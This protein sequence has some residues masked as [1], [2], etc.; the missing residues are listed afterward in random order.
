MKE[1]TDHC[2][3]VKVSGKVAPVEVRPITEDE[4]VRWDRLMADRHYLGSRLVGESVRYVALWEGRWAALLGWSSAAYKTGHRDRWIGWSEDQRH[5][6]L[7]LVANNAR[8]LML[9]EERRP[10]LASMVLSRTV[11]RLS[12]DW[13]QA[14]GHGVVLAETF[15][16]PSRFRGTC[17]RAAGWEVLGQT[18]GY[19]RHAG[20]YRSGSHP[21]LSLIYPLH[22]RTQ[23]ML[24]AVFLSPE[25]P[26]Y[27]RPLLDLNRVSLETLRD[28]FQTFRDPRDPQGQR[29]RYHAVLCLAVLGWFAGQ[30]SYR[31]IGRWVESLPQ[32][33]LKRVGCAR[34]GWWRAPGTE[35]IRRHLHATDPEALHEAV[36]CWLEQESRRQS[37]SLHWVRSM[38]EKTPD[39]KLTM[40]FIR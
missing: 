3:Q 37:R 11:R 4:R 36:S 14:Y 10:N 12:A 39:L 35:T 40:G 38:W 15:V 28:I 9:S 8:F 23:E 31:G 2:K 16:D 26:V 20:R 30:R 7:S 32:S 1:K 24:S 18:Q 19:A 21:K 33:V 13:E 25:L 5:Q 6:R 34:D 17:Y 27:P 22:R 29:H